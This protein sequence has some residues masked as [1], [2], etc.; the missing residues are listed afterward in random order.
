MAYRFKDTGEVD[1][2][3]S[4]ARLYNGVSEDAGVDLDDMDMQVSLFKFSVY[5]SVNVISSSVCHSVCVCVCVH[6]CWSLGAGAEINDI[7]PRMQ[8]SVVLFICSSVCPPLRQ[9]VCLPVRTCP[10]T[11]VLM[12]TK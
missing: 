10:Y 12:C 5:I 6:P 8:I 11:L 7:R 2:A 3:C 4:S 9:P 1:T